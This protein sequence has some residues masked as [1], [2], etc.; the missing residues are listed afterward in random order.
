MPSGMNEPPSRL[1][2]AQCRDA[3]LALV[4]LLLVVAHFA[5][6]FELVLPAIIVLV[7]AM[8]VPGLFRPYAFLWWKVAE[9]MATVGSKVLLTVIYVLVVMPMGLIRRALGADPLRL[10][11]WGGSGS[12]LV[13]RETPFVPEDH[14]T[15]Y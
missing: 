4:F 13:E 1:T 3:A 10:R 7:A 12:V 9:G 15:P 6:W 11:S 14:E 5:E 8:L 2:I